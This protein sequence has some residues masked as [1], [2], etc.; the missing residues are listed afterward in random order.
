MDHFKK[1]SKVQI[2]LL[3]WSLSYTYKSETSILDNT[4]N[5]YLTILE[6]MKLPFYV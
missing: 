2:Q 4:E 5:L 3:K 1:S 6:S